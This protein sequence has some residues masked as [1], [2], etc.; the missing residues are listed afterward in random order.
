[1]RILA[2]DL[3]S[4]T[5]FAIGDTDGEP[6]C[7][8]LELP[9]T[10]EDVGTFLLAFD[11][12]I[13][14]IVAL[15]KPTVICFEAPILM[16]GKTSLATARK[17]MG[18]ASHTEFVA[19]DLHITCREANIMTVKAFFAG[20]GRASKDDM[21]AAARRYGWTPRNDNEAD[22]LAV[23]SYSSHTM[24]P[25]HSARFRMGVMGARA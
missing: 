22:A 7:G 19:A 15:E 20:T 24:A 21:I 14:D 3:S 5:G 6:R 18:L 12:W 25:Q 23:W 4:H 1:M 13:R 9:K 8:T 2:I 10:G 11:C 17:L 16:A